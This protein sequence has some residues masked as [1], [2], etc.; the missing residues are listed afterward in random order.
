METLLI[1]YVIN[2]G[3]VMFLLVPCSLLMLGAVIQGL[4]RLRSGRVLPGW[5]TRQ[6]ESVK[7]P[8]MR[9][10]FVIGLSE[11]RAPL[12]RAVW[13]TLRLHNV[14]QTRRP[15]QQELLISMEEASA[16]VGDEMRDGLA[17]LATIYTI[18]PLLGLLGTILGMMNTF[19]VFA[20][21]TERSVKLLSIGIQEALVT[22]LWGLGI[23]IPAYVAAQ[24]LERIIADYERRR[25]PEAVSRVLE[26]IYGPPRDEEE[27]AATPRPVPAPVVAA[28][29]ARPVVSPPEPRAPARPAAEPRPAMRPGAPS[30]AAARPAA[31]P[32]GI[33]ARP[34]AV[35]GQARPVA[36]PAAPAQ[37]ATGPAPAAPRPDE[38]GR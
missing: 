10:R 6:A 12:A 20:Q 36:R 13:L 2:G 5:V 7:S 34:A 35:P 9:R 8:D 16:E 19:Y 18:A 24:W 38:A 1:K 25:L 11:S 15:P 30:P 4:I 26:A 28:G 21:S 22:T 29:P 14:A 32:G 31:Q 37:P 23:A 3:P 17:L 33:A 27:P